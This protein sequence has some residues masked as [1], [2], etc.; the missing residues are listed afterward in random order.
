MKDSAMFKLKINNISYA[1]LSITKITCTINYYDPI[2]KQNKIAK[3]SA[4]C[5]P[6]DEFD[7][8]LGK[9]IAKSRAKQNMYNKFCNN[10]IN[11]AHDTVLKHETYL[12]REKTYCNHI[13]HKWKK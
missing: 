5:H 12:Y 13:M 11:I 7:E 2:T 9:R 10:F 3:G 8:E 1:Y 6:N 4:I